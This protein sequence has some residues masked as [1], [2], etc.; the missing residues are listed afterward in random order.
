MRVIKSNN[1]NNGYGKKG[2]REV[3][4]QGKKGMVERYKR[5]WTKTKEWL[6]KN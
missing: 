1:L 6:Y 2:V 4:N 5:D 3:D